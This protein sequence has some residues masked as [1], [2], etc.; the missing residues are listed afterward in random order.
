MWKRYP[1][2][3]Q[4]VGSF[5]VLFVFFWAWSVA[6][7][8]FAQ[9]VTYRA[10]FGS[11]VLCSW[12]KVQVFECDSH[13]LTFQSNQSICNLEFEQSQFWN[14]STL[15]FGP[16]LFSI[17]FWR[18]QKNAKEFEATIGFSTC[19]ANLPSQV[20]SDATWSAFNGRLA[21]VSEGQAYFSRVHRTTT[22]L[23]RTLRQLCQAHPELTLFAAEEFCTQALAEVLG[24]FGGE[25]MLGGK[26]WQKL[27]AYLHI[28]N[29]LWGGRMF[30]ICTSPLE[31][32]S[33][34][35]DIHNLTT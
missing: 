21:A 33:H 10:M 24:S 8:Q 16:R 35:S 7:Y 19:S 6:S 28:C 13:L 9:V 14:S 34:S 32:S 11:R 5:D 31:S 12:A 23:A 26:T 20:V 30:W 25:G 1:A 15:R 17:I 3:T 4:L 18:F 27:H 2:S 22:S 29:T